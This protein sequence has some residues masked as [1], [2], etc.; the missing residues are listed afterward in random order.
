MDLPQRRRLRL[1]SFNYAEARAYFVTI[2]TQQNRCVFGEI[3]DGRMICN[4][5]GKIVEA[6]WNEIPMH[7]STAELDAF[8]VMPNHV[9]GV[10]VLSEGRA[11]HAR[12]LQ[13]VVGS[14]KASV[15]KAAEFPVWQRSYWDRIVRDDKELDQI[16]DYVEENPSRWL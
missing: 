14:F 3:N 4:S 5:L 15:S 16:R 8:V 10:I 9:H 11:G 6:C 13:V 1:P 12:P 2:C 7:Y